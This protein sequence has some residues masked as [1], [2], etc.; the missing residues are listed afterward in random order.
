[1]YHASLKTARKRED[2]IR[3]DSQQDYRTARASNE[4]GWSRVQEPTGA[5]GFLVRSSQ[6]GEVN[7]GDEGVET[8]I[9]GLRQ[10]LREGDGLER[11]RHGSYHG[12]SRARAAHGRHTANR[13]G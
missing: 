11:T 7:V 3:G 4:C 13:A 8:A 9:H 10:V 6:L 2:L 1:M 5:F 12:H